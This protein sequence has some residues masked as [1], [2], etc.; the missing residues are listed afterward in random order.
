MRTFLTPDGKAGFALNGD[1]IV[2]VFRHPDGPKGVVPAML[3]LATS[4]GGRRLDAFDT[5]LPFLYGK[6]GFRAVS[7]TPFNPE[8]QPEGWNRWP[9]CVVIPGRLSRNTQ[10]SPAISRADYS[11]PLLY[12]TRRVTWG[13]DAMRSIEKAR[14]QI[15]GSAATA[16]PLGARL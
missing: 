3:D 7:R 12:P 11:L 4:Q 10:L 9:D 1:D 15:S 16:G 14:I 8:Y 2:S 6:S 13:L 5:T